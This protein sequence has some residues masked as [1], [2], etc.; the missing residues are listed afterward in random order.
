ME[1]YDA[2][3]EVKDVTPEGADEPTPQPSFAIDCEAQS[4]NRFYGS[5]GALSCLSEVGDVAVIEHQRLHEHAK[6]LNL[7]PNDFRILCRN[8][9]LAAD[10]GFDVDAACFLTTIVDGEVVVRRNSGKSESIVNVLL[11]LDKYLQNDPDFKMYNIYANETNLLFEDSAIGLVSPKDP[12]L[13]EAVQNYIQ[14]YDDVE[15]CISETDGAQTIAIN[16][17]LTISFAIFTLLI[18]Y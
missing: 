18:K 2:E 14:L 8:G 13:S 11:S 16:L 10:T 17:I 12:S 15:N 3:N 6:S 5:R 7:D 9:S 1:D 4:T